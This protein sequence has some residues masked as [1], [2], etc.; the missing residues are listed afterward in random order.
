MTDEFME[1]EKKE[2]AAQVERAKKLLADAGFQLS[3]GG[4][5]CCGSAWVR[6]THNEED[7]IFDPD[8]AGLFRDYVTIDMHDGERET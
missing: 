7:V 4:C 6:L 1:E 5:G 3:L 8:D 2:A